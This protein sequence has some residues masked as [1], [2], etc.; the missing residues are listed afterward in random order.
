MRLLP[1]H[2][3]AAEMHGVVPM[4]DE[5]IDLARPAEIDFFDTAAER[6]EDIERRKRVLAHIGIDRHIAEIESNRR[7]SSP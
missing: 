5:M 2:R 7:S 1:P 4:H 3:L 6:L